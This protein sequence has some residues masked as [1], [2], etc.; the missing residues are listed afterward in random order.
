MGRAMDD[1][2]WAS[3]RCD[4]PWTSMRQSPQSS[5]E[6]ADEWMALPKALEMPDLEDPDSILSAA[7]TATGS[8]TRRM[9]GRMAFE[10]EFMHDCESAPSSAHDTPAAVDEH[11]LLGKRARSPQSVCPFD[12]ESNVSQLIP[13]CLDELL[14]LV[15]EKRNKLYTR[16]EEEFGASED[17]CSELSIE[18]LLGSSPD[19][20]SASTAPPPPP[21]PLPLQQHLRQ[22]LHQHLQLPPMCTQTEELWL[23]LTGTP[24]LSSDIHM[25]K[26]MQRP[27]AFFAFDGTRRMKP[28]APPPSPLRVEPESPP[29]FKAVLSHLEVLR[30]ILDECMVDSVRAAID[31]RRVRAESLCEVDPTGHIL[32]VVLEV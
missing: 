27:E 23:C 15:E 30:T 2:S 11:P 20:C 5:V 10:D 26:E 19:L 1:D 9:G 29:A 25:Q 3:L 16:A 7:L 14:V 18:E 31:R 28:V 12:R 6:E 13:T 24:S 21:T 22:H 17:N 4:S 8:A 32:K